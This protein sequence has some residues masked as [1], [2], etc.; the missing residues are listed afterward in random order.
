M[1]GV[2]GATAR[3]LGDG[4]HWQGA[5][6]VP[7][8][9][10]EHVGISAVAVLLAA[11]VALPAGLWV[12]HRG[13]GGGL[14]VAIANVGRA[15]PSFGLLILGVLAF[16][17]GAGPVVATLVLLAI[18]PILVNT[19]TGVRDVDADLKD[20]AA[21]Q[22]LSGRQ[23]LL[24][25]ELPSALPLVLAG[26]RTAAVLVVATATLAAVVPGVGGLGT[27]VVDGIG[28]QDDGKAVAGALL[29]ALLATLT[30]GGLALVERWVVPAGV[31]REAGARRRRAEGF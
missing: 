7:H 16:G 31:R 14:V 23:V 9:L 19:A 10:A 4:Q 17:I 21:G 26:V 11:A 6:G 2:I 8:R 15:V 24:Q 13:S 25:V 27:Y 3:W 28:Q 22:G 1:S 5:A 29:V 12:G 30:E 20:A 18:P